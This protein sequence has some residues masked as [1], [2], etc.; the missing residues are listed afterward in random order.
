MARRLTKRR[1]NALRSIHD[2]PD[3]SPRQL[4]PDARA[5]WDAA[6]EEA[7]AVYG[8][9][10][11]AERAAWRDVKLRWRQTGKKTW[12]RC[13]NGVCYWPE[14]GLLPMPKKDLISL[15]VLV[16]YVYI[17]KAGKLQVRTLDRNHPPILWWDDGRKMLYAFPKQPYP[18]ECQPIPDS[19]WE[20]FE[21]F[22]VWHQ[23][24]PQ[25]KLAVPIPNVRVDA[26]GAADSLSY[27]S[28]KWNDDDPDPALRDAQE[29]IHNHWYDVWIW[30]DV[31]RGVPNAIVITGGE[32]DLHPRGLI[33]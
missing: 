12:Q 3:P 14:G 2:P 10:D 15:G 29:Y 9:R 6:Y 28:D 23:R 17:D 20:A 26:V 24:D 19:M 4:P 8:K 32:L 30:S 5:Q 21:L 22:R 18:Q 25:C 16:E 7:Y 33:H 1:A 13:K 11:L 27:A 31:S